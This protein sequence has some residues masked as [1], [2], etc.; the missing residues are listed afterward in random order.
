[1][2]II[3]LYYLRHSLA[4]ARYRRQNSGLLYSSRPTTLDAIG[5]SIVVSNI[6]R[7]FRVFASD[8][9]RARKHRTLGES[10]SNLVYVSAPKFIL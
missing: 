4:S 7:G 6:L 9:I 2:L 3:Y 8:P 10:S 1:M 5:N